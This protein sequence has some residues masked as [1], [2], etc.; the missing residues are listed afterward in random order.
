MSK[1]GA[2]RCSGDGYGGRSDRHGVRA[3]GRAVRAAQGVR[4]KRGALS[5]LCRG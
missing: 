5:V 4:Q 1:W 3:D 2:T